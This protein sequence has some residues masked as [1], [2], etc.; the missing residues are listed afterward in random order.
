M[1]RDVREFGFDGLGH[2]HIK[3][4]I[5]SES[6]FLGIAYRWHP[7]ILT[8]VGCMNQYVNTTTKDRLNHALF[9]NV[10]VFPDF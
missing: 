9:I 4:R 1:G 10:F 3:E 5:R 7:N 2:P 8:E 6:W